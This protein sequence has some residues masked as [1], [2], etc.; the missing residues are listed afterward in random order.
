MSN[1]LE[2]NITGNPFIDSGIYALNMLVS[3]KTRIDEIGK[4]GKIRKIEKMGKMDV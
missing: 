2:L 3:K 4:M 1:E